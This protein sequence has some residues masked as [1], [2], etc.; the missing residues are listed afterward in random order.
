MKRLTLV[1]LTIVASLAAA[2]ARRSAKFATLDLAVAR[3]RTDAQ[4]EWR[5]VQGLNL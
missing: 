1:G 2:P 3:L 4:L 5:A